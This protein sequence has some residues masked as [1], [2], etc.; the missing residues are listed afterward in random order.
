M[1]SFLAR[2][3]RFASGG[4]TN[5]VNE[6]LVDFFK[7]A[8]FCQGIFQNLNAVT[9]YDK[10]VVE[11]MA[12]GKMRLLLLYHKCTKNIEVGRTDV[13]TTRWESGIER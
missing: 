13:R 8:I 9:V 11:R 6:S 10:I 3:S 5:I 4:K 7:H 12:H 1:M 2:V